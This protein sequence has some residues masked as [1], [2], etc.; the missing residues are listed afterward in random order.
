SVAMIV[1]L[2]QR[3][4]HH[5]VPLRTALAFGGIAVVLVFL[6]RLNSFSLEQFSYATTDTYSGFIAG[7]LMRSAAGAAGMGVLI[8]LIVAASEPV[9]RESFPGLPSIGRTLTWNGLRSRSF[10]MA[11]IV[12]IGLTFFFFAYQTVFYLVANKLGAWAPLDVPFSDQ[13]NTAVPW[14]AVLFGGFAPAV[15]EEMQFRAFA[16]PFLRRIF[17]YSSLAIVVAA[18]NC[19]FLH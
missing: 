3:L 7:Y 9:Y 2:L 10:F 4:R 16:I 14:V 18:F 5:D 12:G 6:D 13:L 17:R 1:V 19:G 15:L 11:N 8:F